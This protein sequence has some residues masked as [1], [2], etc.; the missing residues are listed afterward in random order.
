[1]LLAAVN[2]AVSVRRIRFTSSGVRTIARLRPGIGTT[3]GPSPCR[4]R[5]SAT[6]RTTPA[7]DWFFSSSF[8]AQ[9]RRAI[10]PTATNGTATC[11]R[12]RAASVGETVAVD[13]GTGAP[14]VGG[15]R[16]YEG[17]PSGAHPN[18]RPD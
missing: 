12:S 2:D 6:R 11:P 3:T 13:A 10:G 1:S 8:I 4:L 15:D 7:S 18:V 5:R 17:F 14:G 16:T 9:R